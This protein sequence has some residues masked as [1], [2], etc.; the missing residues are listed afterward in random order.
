M[1]AFVLKKINYIQNHSDPWCLRSSSEQNQIFLLNSDFQ[2]FPD[3]AL[4]SDATLLIRTI[5]ILHKKL[6][7]I[8]KFPTVKLTS[9]NN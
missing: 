9:K 2:L 5:N 4:D 1:S 3:L 7:S 6:Y 8:L